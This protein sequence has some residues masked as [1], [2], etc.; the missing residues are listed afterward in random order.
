[1]TVRRT[2]WKHNGDG[3]SRDEDEL[4]VEEPL[5]IRIRGQSLVVTM[6]TPSQ[7]DSLYHEDS[8]LAAGFLLS[9]GV[10]RSRDDIARIEPCARPNG[11]NIVNV[12]L[13]SDVS[14]QPEKL[15]RHVFAS[16][17]CG[18]CGRSCIDAVYHQYP[19]IDTDVQTCTK[20]LTSLP[21]KLHQSQQAFHRTGGLHAAG[22]FGVDGRVIVVREDVGRHN[23]VDKVL[24]YAL[25]EDRLPLNEHILLVSG[26]TS[27][28]IVQK[29][30]SAGV[31]I[32]A[33]VSAPS[34]LA[35]ELAQAHGMTLVGFLRAGRMNIYCGPERISDR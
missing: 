15:S 27:F 22:L 5:E 9:E 10:V 13:A 6:R 2:I 8:E 7:P 23:A 29:A 30:L 3:R 14:Y 4:A 16:S 17:S 35:V 32:V 11:Q 24:G 18:I 26:R 33:S 21:Q 1:M 20:V 28:E 12:F 19:P 31:P 34:N 25:L